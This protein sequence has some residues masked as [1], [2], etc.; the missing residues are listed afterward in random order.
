MRSDRPKRLDSMRG[1]IAAGCTVH[2]PWPV[3][4]P[5]AKSLLPV[6]DKPLIYYPLSV[7][8]EMG[9]RDVLVI[10][11]P[12]GV[13][14]LQRMLGDGGQWG[15]RFSYALQRASR[16]VI[17]ALAC[18]EEFVGN[19]PCSLIFGDRVFLETGFSGRF[20]DSSGAFRGAHVITGLPDAE[21]PSEAATGLAVYDSTVFEKVRA[22]RVSDAGIVGLHRLY[23][24]EGRLRVDALAKDHG[25]W[26]N[27]DTPELLREASNRIEDVQGRSKGKLGC[28]E[29]VCWRRGYIDD[30]QL[31]VLSD[32]VPCREYGTYLRSLL[33]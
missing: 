3:T 28:P 6:F 8:I 11:V 16:R 13:P 32:L 15:L 27:V 22:V 31:E 33:P 20:T 24:E 4:R 9:I 21:I 25:T 1:L 14:Q 5:T 23:R 7:L 17:D 18:A 19:S 30:E 2:K 26:L 10:S 12:S 29:E